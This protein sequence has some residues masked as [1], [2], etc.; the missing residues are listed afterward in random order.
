MRSLEQYHSVGMVASQVDDQ[1][2][3]RIDVVYEIHRRGLALTGTVRQSLCQCIEMLVLGGTDRDDRVDALFVRIR[4]DRGVQ[5]RFIG[6]EFQH[7]TQQRHAERL[8][9]VI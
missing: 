5:C 6:A 1:L 4:A 3:G 9:A 7:G 2:F 8:L